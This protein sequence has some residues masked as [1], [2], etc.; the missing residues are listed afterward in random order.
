MVL[1]ML[2]IELLGLLKLM[3]KVL[4]QQQVRRKFNLHTKETS[5]APQNRTNNNNTNNIGTATYCI[6]ILDYLLSRANKEAE[7]KQADYWQ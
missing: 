5:G 1:G 2:D 3:C 6:N 4:D 7:K